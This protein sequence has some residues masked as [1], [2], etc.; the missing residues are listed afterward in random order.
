MDLSDY[1]LTFSPCISDNDREIEQWAKNQI[2]YIQNNTEL[3]YGDMSSAVG[4]WYRHDG[5]IAYLE[6]LAEYVEQRTPFGC[7]YP[8]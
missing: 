7:V 3:L 5:P 4:P 8:Y 2:I 6:A 1:T